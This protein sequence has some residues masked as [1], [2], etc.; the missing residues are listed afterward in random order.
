MPRGDSFP[1]ALERGMI[2]IFVE[3]SDQL[4]DI[5]S[6]VLSRQAMKK[7]A[8]LLGRERIGIFDPFP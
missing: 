2:Q 3:V 7:H 5:H 1:G 8:L 4:I 6:H